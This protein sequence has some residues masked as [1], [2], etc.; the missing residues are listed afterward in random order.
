MRE[1]VITA[2]RGEFR[3]FRST[4][5]RPVGDYAE[6][7]ITADQVENI[8]LSSMPDAV[9]NDNITL[10]YHRLS[11]Q[12]AQYLD[13]EKNAN[14]CTFAV[15]GSLSAGAGIRTTDPPV[16]VA[17]AIRRL[18]LS[19]RVRLRMLEQLSAVRSTG[20][21]LPSRALAA[22]NR[23]VFY[24]MGMAYVLFL[25]V[26]RRAG[27]STIRDQMVEFRDR[28][29]VLPVSLG[30]AWP[31]VDRE[32]LVGGFEAYCWAKVSESAKER[33]EWML[34]ANLRL[35]EYEQRRLQNWLT[36]AIHEPLIRWKEAQLERGKPQ[37]VSPWMHHGWE[38]L[39]AHRVLAVELGGQTIPVTQDLGEPPGYAF[40][41]PDLRSIDNPSLRD[42]L[43]RLDHYHLQVGDEWSGEGTAV[44]SWVNID[45][46]LRFV[47]ALFRSRQQYPAVFQA[48][49]PDTDRAAIAAGRDPHRIAT[50]RIELRH[51][52]VAESGGFGSV[53]LDQLRLEG[54]DHVDQVVAAH[55]RSLGE[56]AGTMD[57]LMSELRKP[58]DAMSEP[59]R[60]YV[61]SRAPIPSFA[62]PARIER[63]QAFYRELRLPLNLALL[64]ASLP[65]AYGAANGVQ[66]LDTVSELVDNPKRR[67]GQ[68]AQFM[69]DIT[70][71]DP[72]D[73]SSVAY[74][75][76][77]GVRLMHAGVRH[78][79]LAN[80][81]NPRLPDQ[82]DSSLGTPINQEDLLG[83]MLSFIVPPLD[84]LERV[85][86][87]FDR[88][89]AEDYVHLWCVVAFMLGVDRTLL[90]DPRYEDLS[91]T[92]SQARAAAAKVRSRQQQPSLAGQRLTEA[93]IT[94][95]DD[96]TPRPLRPLVP[97]LVRLGIGDDLADALRVPPRG[98]ADYC[99]DRAV[100]FGSTI[101]T[102]A[103]Y[104]WALPRV[105]LRLGDEWYRVFAEGGYAQD[106]AFRA[107]G[108]RL[109]DEAS[110]NRATELRK[111]NRISNVE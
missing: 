21:R 8:A 18:P 14:W 90:S 45:Q 46:R 102:D 97:A 79:L 99:V 86:W 106:P 77:R 11:E 6:P 35:G 72:L 80:D 76:I 16:R 1:Q 29:P 98:L 7:L 67:I 32:L 50:A 65:E 66:V 39:M 109:S 48:P 47:A 51:E 75:S 81:A 31:H 60:N 28:M 84:F 2:P 92:L 83:T 70:M 103:W 94:A 95:L 101:Q 20:R 37:T 54:D 87:H 26:S 12:L 62:D 42:L 10:A 100:R 64:V 36:I 93:L 89:L 3:G 55:W 110:D 34:L 52:I 40:L 111:G 73:R 85:G 104:R 19:Q 25:E 38:R 4:R 59:V 13:D 68:T 71:G 5:R 33:A 96:E 53:R 44:A 82:W 69:L 74:Q 15:W 22:G 108:L 58:A 9:R 107:R 57:R 27:E 78:M 24:E 56:R 49:Y 41:P 63:G 105:A 88:R 23:G 43:A 91:L 30:R 17:E 61:H